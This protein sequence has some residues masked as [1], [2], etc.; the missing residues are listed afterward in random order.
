MSLISVQDAHFD[1]GRE[2]ILRSVTVAVHAGVRC[3]LV[4]A[5]GTGKTPLL[6]DLD[7]EMQMHG[8]TRQVTGGVQVRLLRQESTLRAT[9]GTA[10]EPAGEP[11]V[12]PLGG[13]AG[14]LRD[15][16]AGLAFT[17]EQEQAFF[18]A[19]DDWQF[20]IFFTLAFTGLRVGELTHL[21]IDNDV[22]LA[23][24]IVR[25]RNKPRVGWQVKTRNVRDIPL[26]TEAAEI[27]RAAA[28][29]AKEEIL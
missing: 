3:A 28:R 24:D 25:V 4:G 23:H 26:V 2:H 29:E 17:V 16:V 9:D 14:G 13:L 7:G 11:V 15:V 10:G 12:G 27:I 19:C 21:L 8:G 18:K 20:P 1:Y 6:A 5:N 22:D